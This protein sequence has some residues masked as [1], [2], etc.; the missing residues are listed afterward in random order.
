TLGADTPEGIECRAAIHWVSVEHG[1]DAEIRIYD[2]LFTTENPDDAE[3]GFLTV[4]NPDSLKVL[5]AKV[6]PSLAGV[7]SGFRCQFERTGYFI[8]DA[9]DHN[10]GTTPVFNRTVGLRDSSKKK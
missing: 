7:V 2:R 4:L 3:G 5:T 6:E 9:K 8:A 1:A 10:P